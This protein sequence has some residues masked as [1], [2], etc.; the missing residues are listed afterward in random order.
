MYETHIPYDHFYL[1]ANLE[2][3]FYINRKFLNQQ[4]N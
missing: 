1:N 4:L 3:L 2:N